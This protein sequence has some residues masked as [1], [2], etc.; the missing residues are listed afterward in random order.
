M[1]NFF[2]VFSQSQRMLQRLMQCTSKCI[3]T[4]CTLGLFF[5]SSVVRADFDDGC[6]AVLEDDD[7]SIIDA[8]DGSSISFTTAAQRFYQTHGDDYDFLM[9]FPNFDHPH[10][11]FHQLVFND[12]DGL[13]SGRPTGFNNRASYNAA[14]RLQSINNYVNFTTFP[15]DP[16]ARIGNNNDSTL[17]LL[18]QEVGHRWAAF[19]RHAAGDDSLLGRS[20]SHWSYYF[21]APSTGPRGG[22]S[23]LEGNAWMDNGDGTFTTLSQTDGF[24]E[25]DQYLMG[26]RA[27]SAV[28]PM[29]F[30]QSPSG[31][32]GKASGGTPYRPHIELADTVN[33]TRVD[34][35]INDIIDANGARDPS[36][37]ESPK[38]LRQAFI[39]LAEGGTA[40]PQADIDQLDAVRTAWEGYFAQETDGLG[41]VDTC[42]R[43]QPVD[44]VFLVD[45]SGS[46][47]DDL[48]VLKA[49]TPDLVS[50]I[51]DAAP[52]SRFALASYSDFPFL[53]YGNP[54][55]NDFGYRMDLALTEDSD[56]FIDAVDALT[57]YNAEDL[58]QSTY[59]AIYQVLTGAG[60]DLTGDGDFDDLGEIAPSDIGASE[61]RPLFIYVFT[62]AP[63][64]D[65]DVNP[66]Y[67][68]PGFPA[69]GRAEVLALLQNTPFIFGLASG[70]DNNQLQELADL[71]DGDV[72]DLGEDSSGFD[73]AIIEAIETTEPPP[74]ENLS[75]LETLK[76]RRAE[77]NWN[78]VD[79]ED[80]AE[81]NLENEGL[82]LVRVSGIIE[83]P[84]DTPY[85]DIEREATV[86][87]IT[88][89]APVFFSEVALKVK[90]SG[91]RWQSVGNPK[92]NISWLSDTSATF[93]LQGIF[94]PRTFA[95]DGESHPISLTLVLSL[96]A[97]L[98]SGD[99]S[100]SEGEWDRAD[101]EH[102]R[103]KLS[104]EPTQSDADGDGWDD[105]YDN[106]PF[107]FNPDQG[108]FNSN[109]IG[110]VCE[111]FPGCF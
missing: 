85:G 62:D 106:C 47:D 56:A 14:T 65:S 87:V 5:F 55:S 42:I 101:L 35:T 30:I 80:L 45:V 46:F 11:S 53:P 96:G 37:A 8:T 25:L 61:D 52:S 26:L 51:L 3:F 7:G 99:D 84:S 44:V 90:G 18:A 21:H 23:S 63:F 89:D 48:P 93:R 108:D 105:F 40:V 77:I 24:S 67:P 100:V 2:T 38:G 57:I 82:A 111:D 10:G 75:L 29:W 94:D 70:D 81:G 107:D 17:S 73:A 43:N 104:H 54:A 31:G 12:I 76:I 27:S 33:G 16:E 36:A 95:I 58:P 74:A 15:N 102:W 32:L 19:A 97:Q 110:D 79:E 83:L 91:D 78:L 6:I 39:L 86:T 98:L 69:A 68:V 34:I 60:R 92:I 109:F 66:N 13:G 59:E 22:A 64:H 1:S 71:T 9:F 20:G 103:L 41:S 4:G 49:A 88:A 28:S 72:F 50:T